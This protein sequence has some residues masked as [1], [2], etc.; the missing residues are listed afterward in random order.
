MGKA[1]GSECYPSNPFTCSSKPHTITDD[2]GIA[3][4]PIARGVAVL[5][6]VPGINA[7]AVTHAFVVGVSHYPFADGPEATA[8]GESFGITNL[9]GAA[10]SA[11]DIA[12]W[13]LNE[14]RNPDAPLASVRVLLSPTDGEELD[15]RV[16][17]E[18]A[19]P[20]PATRDSVVSEFDEFRQACRENPDNIAF[21]YFAGHGIQLNKRGAVVLL[22]DFGVMGKGNKL[23]GSIDVAGCRDAMDETGN[24]HHQIWF[25]DACRQFPEIARKF[26]TLAGAYTAD[27]G[28]GQVDASP[29]F[30][31]SSSRESAFG[32]V[33]GTTILS[34]ALLE[35]LR[36]DAAVGPTNDCDD[37]HVST[38]ALIRT[39]QGKVDAILAGREEQTIDITGRVREMVAHR[40]AKPPHVDIVVNLLPA[41]ASPVPVHELL[42]DGEMP[43]DIDQ[44]WPLR[45]RGDAGLYLLKVTVQPPLTKGVN[46][47]LNALPPGC[48]HDVRVS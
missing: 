44:S 22:H 12:A 34:D 32:A 7:P 2:S 3:V 39:L 31:A 24:A 18:L 41:D 28:V 40:F 6:T 27:E 1:D 9:T 36:A 21:V 11:S 10:K 42:F 4:G 43:Q 17:R 38:T 35:A 8:D 46:K 29:L 19:G 47:P 45:F 30:L 13:L 15:E 37:W 16:A 14:Y 26:E 25:S 48:E 33:G 20:S 23:Y 5:I